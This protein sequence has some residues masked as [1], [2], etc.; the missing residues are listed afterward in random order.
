VQPKQTPAAEG[1]LTSHH[2][3]CPTW[4]IARSSVPVLPELLG[5]GLLLVHPLKKKKRK[6]SVVPPEIYFVI[7]R[8]MA[9]ARHAIHWQ[10]RRR[11]KSWQG[12]DGTCWHPH[13]HPG[14]RHLPLVEVVRHCNLP[15]RYTRITSADARKRMDSSRHR[16]MHVEGVD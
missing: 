3:R 9:R 8:P 4:R 12:S 14:L 13:L 15:T 5:Y 6:K 1:R 2:R 11:L 16:N 7:N 10:M